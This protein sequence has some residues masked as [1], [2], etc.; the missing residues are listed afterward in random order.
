[1]R[2]TIMSLV[3]A[4]AISVAIP[5]GVQAASPHQV[6]QAGLTPPLNPAYGPWICTDTGGGPICRGSLSDSWTN[7]DSELRCGN[8][9]VYSTG[10][11]QTEAVRW[12]LPDGRA[13]HTFFKNLSTEVWTLSPLEPGRA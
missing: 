2:N 8:D 4:L 7:A 12:H 11:L 1:M 9:L 5:L 3:V 13:T 10:N 6:D